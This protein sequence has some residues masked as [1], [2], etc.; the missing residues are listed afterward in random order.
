MLLSEYAMHSYGI[1]L[2]KIEIIISSK[3]KLE[4]KKSSIALIVHWKYLYY[5]T[6]IYI[7]DC[8]KYIEINKVFYKQMQVN[9]LYV[10]TVQVNSTVQ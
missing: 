2:C 8:V 10:S 7:I 5:T 6:S 4:Q 1:R 3:C 9:H